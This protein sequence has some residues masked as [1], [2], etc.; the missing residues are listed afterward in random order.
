MKFL[1]KYP[2]GPYPYEKLIHEN[3][4]RRGGGPEYELIDTGV[5]EGDRYFDVF[6][7]Y[8]KADTEDICIRIEVC[9]RGPDDAAL[10]L[11]PTLWFRNF[12]S[13]GRT[14]HKRPSLRAASASVVDAGGYFLS[15]EGAPELLFCENE[16]NAH[17]LW[18]LDGPPYPKDGIND[19][20]ISGAKTVNPDRIG[21]KGAARYRLNVPA[22]GS[23]VMRLRLRKGA[24]QAPDDA[25]FA[26]RK[27]EAD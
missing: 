21:T 1:Y 8:A 26:A 15:C 5:F 18:G 13:W 4:A 9:N 10:E 20:V 12:W 2:Q 27:Q 16:T 19:F 3:R 17:R 25:V 24:P 11:L 14:K 7:E 6:I 23:R 22:R